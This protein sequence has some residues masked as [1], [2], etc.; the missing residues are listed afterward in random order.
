MKIMDRYYLYL[1]AFL[2]A[3][4][5]LSAIEIR[6]ISRLE[7]TCSDSLREYRELFVDSFTNVYD[8]IPLEQ[9]RVRDLDVFLNAAFDVE[10][11]EFLNSNENSVFFEALSDSGEILGFVSFDLQREQNLVYVRQLAVAESFKGQG[12]GRR[13]LFSAF[14]A[15]PNLQKIF[16]VTRRLNT[17][18]IDFY[19]HLGFTESNN[20]HSGQDPELYASYEWNLQSQILNISI[21]DQRVLDIPIK[22]SFDPIVDLLSLD[23]PRI[24]HLSQIDSKYPKSHEEVGFVRFGVY[25]ALLRVIDLLP[26]DWGIAVF[27]GYRPMEIQKQYFHQTYLLLLERYKD[28]H[29]ALEECK[30][31][32]SDPELCPV[33]TT[34]GAI[35]MALFCKDTDGNERLID[36]GQFGVIFGMND[37]AASYSKSL[38]KEQKENRSIFFKACIG[39]GLVNYAK[40]W[41]HFS[42]GDRLWA[43][44]FNKEAAVYAPI[45]SSVP[46]MPLAKTKKFKVA[47]QV[48]ETS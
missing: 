6:P 22:E 46:V 30:K 29:Q 20:L 43:L 23:H 12:I 3:I 7:K 16:L 5:D 42:Y 36:L 40:E 27:E 33:H 9:L 10:Q 26:R 39:A 4:V 28:S 18:A 47:R 15:M 32:V 45:T 38:S 14:E 1:L 34:G 44:A 2:F 48:Q 41:W 8:N 19:L 13:L 24:R 21:A 37:Q 31:L 11:E 25:K 35:D 17:S